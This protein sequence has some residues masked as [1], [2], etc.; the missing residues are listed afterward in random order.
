MVREASPRGLEQTHILWLLTL[1]LP[2]EG[3]GQ[4]GGRAAWHPGPWRDR[5]EAGG[6]RSRQSAGLEEDFILPPS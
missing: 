6:G 4:L 1:F 3:V 2:C 5:L